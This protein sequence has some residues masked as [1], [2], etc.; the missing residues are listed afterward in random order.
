MIRR[1]YE[2]GYD[3]IVPV[4]PPGATLSPHS[5]VSPSQVGKIPG[6]WTKE[7]WV[8]FDLT[9]QEYPDLKQ[10]EVYESIGSNF[11]LAADHF[12]GLDIDVDDE[13]L[14]LALVP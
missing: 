2:L 9:K 11:G 10:A 4:I 8:G 1:F 12:P 5:R 7:G 6:R 14:T 3:C 13:E